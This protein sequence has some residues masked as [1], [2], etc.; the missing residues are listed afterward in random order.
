LDKF[1][2]I[3]IVLFFVNIGLVLAVIFLVKAMVT[4]LMKFTELTNDIKSFRDYHKL[5]LQNIEK[6]I[7]DLEEKLL[8]ETKTINNKLN[9]IAKYINSI[10]NN[11]KF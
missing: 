5:S 11:I 2:I 4:S 6:E 1:L 7:G 9:E 3:A 10:K 8:G